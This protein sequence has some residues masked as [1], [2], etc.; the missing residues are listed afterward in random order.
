M[1]SGRRL[2]RLR[3][4]DAGAKSRVRLIPL[5]FVPISSA[6]STVSTS[7]RRLDMTSTEPLVGESQLVSHL[8]SSVL[9]SFRR[10]LL[11]FRG[12]LEWKDKR[13]SERCSKKSAKYRK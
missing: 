2:N 11:P 4:T 12:G 3:A 1:N 6:T 7:A 10:I 9:I 5:L 13:L 8:P